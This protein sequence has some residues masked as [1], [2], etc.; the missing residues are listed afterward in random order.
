MN[1]ARYCEARIRSVGDATRAD[2]TKIGFRSRPSGRQPCTLRGQVPPGSLATLE[3]IA[4]G[5]RAVQLVEMIEEMFEDG[6]PP[7][8]PC[9]VGKGSELG[10]Y[11]DGVARVSLG[12]GR[13]H[14]EIGVDEN[15]GSPIVVC[16]EV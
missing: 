4:S 10:S 7:D 16:H 5:S 8:G 11:G 1:V 12:R 14:P 13:E 6:A 2:G 15:G 3:T 9:L